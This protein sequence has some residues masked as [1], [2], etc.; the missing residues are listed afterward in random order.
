M[1]RVFALLLLVFALSAAPAARAQ[2]GVPLPEVPAVGDV[3][4]QA[5]DLGQQVERP[6]QD[7]RRARVRELLRTHRRELEADPSGMPIVRS[8]ILGLGMSAASIEQA[9][10]GLPDRPHRSA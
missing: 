1:T 9:R 7:L 8:Q 2:L 5:N 10:A 3:V 4:N 6:L